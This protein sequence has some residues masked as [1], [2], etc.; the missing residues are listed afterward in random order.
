MLY[1]VRKGLKARAFRSVVTV[2][3]VSFVIGTLFSATLLTRGVE[4]SINAG[5][6]R[7]G[8]DVLVIPAGTESEAQQ[9][10]LLT[11]SPTAFYMDRS[12]VSKVAAVEGVQEVS[13]QV[14]AVSL[15]AAS[16]CGYSNTFLVGFDPET[17]F[18]VYPWLKMHLTEPLEKD[19]IIVGA[20]IPSLIGQEVPFFGHIFTVAGKLDPTGTAMDDTV[21][22]VQDTLY[23]MAEE[24]PVKALQPL[25]ISRNQISCILVK[26]EPDVPPINVSR[27]I[28]Y[29]LKDLGI[30]AITPAHMTEGVKSQIGPLPLLLPALPAP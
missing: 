3:C 18:T 4:D 28:R 10:I 5:V 19:D 7:L 29:Y 11:T 30:T 15:V 2:L 22:I 20:S 23:K 27:Y 24:S 8:A 26:T 12:V 14:Y 16:C 6:G 9:N 21:F 1:L 25:N 17:D 13:A